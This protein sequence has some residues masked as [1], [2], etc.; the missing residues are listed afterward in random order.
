MYSI[1]AHYKA[2][3]VL[4]KKSLFLRYGCCLDGVTPAQGFGRAGCPEYQTT[5]TTL[6]VT[7]SCFYKLLEVA[8]ETDFWKPFMESATQAVKIVLCLLQL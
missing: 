6:V 1:L 7:T 8:E 4:K 3:T 5:V 2:F